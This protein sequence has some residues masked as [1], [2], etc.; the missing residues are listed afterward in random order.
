MEKLNFT[1]SIHAPKEKV[2]N[3]LWDDTTYRKWTSVF[4]EGSYAETD[5]KEGSK[6]LF[7][8][9]KGH[10][11]VSRIEKN[12]PNEFM[13]IKHLGEIKQGQENTGSDGETS[14]AGAMENYS[15]KEDNGITQLTVELDAEEDY[16]KYFLETFPKALE[17]VKIIAEG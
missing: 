5:W 8:D 4:S 12:L 10:G 14:W 6:V 2:W 17:Q 1:T 16:K 13:S 3:T 7:L 15:L 11:M 9:G